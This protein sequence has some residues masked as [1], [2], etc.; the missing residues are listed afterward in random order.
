MGTYSKC[1]TYFSLLKYHLTT[2]I[3]FIPK[4]FELGGWAFTL[5]LYCVLGLINTV[6][7]FWLLRAS[8]TR[9]LGTYTK[10]SLKTIGKFGSLIT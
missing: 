5:G 7:M 10:L 2:S 6:C 3:L 1:I 4:A 9:K 8:D